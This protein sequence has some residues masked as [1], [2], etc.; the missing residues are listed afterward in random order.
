MT[1]HYDLI[2]IGAGSGGL[3]VVERA[4]EYG[5]KTAVIESGELGGTCVNVGCVPKK[6]MWYGAG[7]THALQDAEDYGFEV[8]R[9]K[10][11][12]KKLIEKRDG[13]IATLMTGTKTVFLESAVL[14]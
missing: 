12:W 2:A 13:Y 5:A 6:I 3:S 1:T 7:L 8:K 11:D 14:I 4:A 9:G 10:L